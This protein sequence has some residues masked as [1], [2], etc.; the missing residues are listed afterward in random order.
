MKRKAPFISLISSAVIV[1]GLI[2]PQIQLYAQLPSPNPIVLEN[3]KPG[4]TGWQYVS[5]GTQADDTNKQI[6]GYT[7]ATS[8]NKGASIDFKVT[9]TPSSI[10]HNPDLAHGILRRNRRASGPDDRAAER[11]ATASLSDG[12]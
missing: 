1:L 12:C 2:V 4:D 11:R 6:K 5:G 7:S 9:V 3:Q 10:I 8:V